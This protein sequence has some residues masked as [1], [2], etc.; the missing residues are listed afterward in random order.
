MLKIVLLISLSFSASRQIC[1]DGCL[2]CTPSNECLLCD[3]LSNYYMSSFGCRKSNLKNCSILDYGGKCLLCM[4]NFYKDSTKLCVRVDPMRQIAN[5]LIYAA[6]DR[7]Q[8][9]QKGFYSFYQKCL[10]VLSSIN[11][12]ELYS[13]PHS[14]IQCSNGFAVNPAT[15]RCVAVPELQ[16]CSYFSLLECRACAEGYILNRNLYLTRLEQQI[17]LISAAVVKNSNK[18]PEIIANEEVCQQIEVSNCSIVSSSKSCHVC[19]KGYFLT[20]QKTC[21]KY[22]RPAIKNCLIYDSQKS[23][24][25]C[26]NS[27]YLETSTK[28]TLISAANS[29]T[30]C[31][32][33]SPKSKTITCTRCSESKYLMNGRCDSKRN[34]SLE[35]KNCKA[36][37]INSDTCAEC[38][39]YFSLIEDGLKCIPARANCSRYIFA[40]DRNSYICQVCELGFYLVTEGFYERCVIGSIIGCLKFASKDT[41][42]QCDDRA[43]YLSGEVCLKH[44]PIYNCLRYKQFNGNECSECVPGYYPF[45]FLN[46]CNKV[47]KIK[48]CASISSGNTCQMC[49]AGYSLEGNTCH[50]IAYSN[51]FCETRDELT[52]KCLRCASGYAMDNSSSNSDCVK[53]HNYILEM[54]DKAESGQVLKSSNVPDNSGCRIC[55]PMSYPF[56][57]SL[58]FSCVSVGLLSKRLEGIVDPFCLKY[59]S[60]ETPLCMACEG[61]L[62]IEEQGVRSC[63]ANIDIDTDD[64]PEIDFSRYIIIQ[65]LLDGGINVMVNRSAKN[66]L[67]LLNCREVIIGWKNGG[68]ASIC[69]RF[70][71]PDILIQIDE[72]VVDN[73]TIY[74]NLLSSYR[75]T[76][77]FY[78]GYEVYFDDSAEQQE[79]S[80]MINSDLCELFFKDAGIKY[81]AKCQ[82]EWTVI[83]VDD[84]NGNKYTDCIL[85]ENIFSHSYITEKN[86]SSSLNRFIS[87]SGCQY[88]FVNALRLAIS[89]IND[90]FSIVGFIVNE[91]VVQCIK[92]SDPSVKDDSDSSFVNHIEGCSFYGVV[93][94]LS[95]NGPLVIR[96]VCLSCSTSYKLSEET[97]TCSFIIGCVCNNIKLCPE[98][99][100]G[101]CSQVS[102]S[103]MPEPKALKDYKALECVRVKS[104]NC[105]FADK[106]ADQD[107]KYDCKICKLGYRLNIDKICEINILP[108]CADEWGKITFFKMPDQWTEESL[109]EYYIIKGLVQDYKNPFGCN[110]CMGGFVLVQMPIGE[111][112]CIYS[113]YVKSNKYIDSQ[114]KYVLNCMKYKNSSPALCSACYSGFILTQDGKNC[115]T[116]IPGCTIAQNLP[117][118]HLCEASINENLVISDT[119]TKIHIPNCSTTIGSESLG[120][121]T[122]IKCLERYILSDDAKNCFPGFV[123]GCKYYKDHS[124][125]SCKECLD[126]YALVKAARRSSYCFKIPN[127]SSCKILDTT[128]EG[129]QGGFHKCNV[130]ES[131]ENYVPSAFV[132]NDVIHSQSFC[133]MLNHIDNC[134][135]Y[136]ASST[137]VEE[138]TFLCSECKMG[139][140]LEN[141]SNSCIL[142]TNIFPECIVYEINQDKCK[143]CPISTFITPNGNACERF[144]TG[145]QFCAAYSSETECTQCEPPMFLQN[146]NGS[147][148]CLL[149]E[150]I[151]NCAIYGGNSNCTECEIGYFLANP[152]LC[153]KSQA[154]NCYT[155]KSLNSCA[156]CDPE[157]PWLGLKINEEGL[158]NCIEKN[159]L[160]CQVSTSEYPFVCVECRAG[161]YLN[162]RSEC[163]LAY[164]I[165]NCEAYESVM[166]CK[167]CK[168]FFI[169]S[170]DRMSCLSSTSNEFIYPNCVDAHFPKK[171]VCVRCNPGYFFRKQCLPAVSE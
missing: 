87:N 140:Y 70:T 59:S 46:L 60:D 56:D 57:L 64:Q 52:F 150:L 135:K 61:K 117:N 11:N 12:C 158:A 103:N 127:E 146:L 105:L 42:I 166:T 75:K 8:Q 131:S 156:S 130:C 14:C 138:N 137:V 89:D 169:L 159:V 155:Y 55:S 153:Q 96:K 67:N 83:M 6:S 20:S 25:E 72:K 86:Y 104:E 129:L 168:R 167:R 124:P 163:E 44:N 118:Q 13:G 128:M 78:L 2:K 51:S 79:I 151:S 58:T 97:G 7:C 74:K 16:T 115:V 160:N 77:P 85:I 40:D 54:C 120:T 82:S 47:E 134:V 107:N 31:L 165:D 109:S 36:H 53:N 15:Y 110:Q 68:V 45:K 122:C 123:Q 125:I 41:C 38:D 65:D 71:S 94:V 143:N 28:C 102:S 108:N 73:Y 162:D 116:S 99:R 23:C 149:S 106:I 80:S 133:L 69:I 171:P 32:S 93:S 84:G 3:Q 114:S 91:P 5:C 39:D 164:G 157:K 26:E 76:G 88:G 9:C 33:Y 35:I 100:C 142:R 34:F 161:L 21:G 48:N 17:S 50:Q 37:S 141:S 43:Y 111:R 112:Q 4:P 62:V 30:D 145:I 81:C 136:D 121:L 1:G 152:T 22:P 101:E 147:I 139:Y 10:P 18:I 148:E 92:L 170:I 126:G 49:E 95:E 132:I 29:I 119:A 66:D 113:S 154:K 144:P 19:N 27:Y 98:N 90:I 24:S 63:S